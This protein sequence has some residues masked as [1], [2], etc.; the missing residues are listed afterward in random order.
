MNLS[1]RIKLLSRIGN[2]FSTICK[3]KD[4]SGFPGF[5]KIY[6]SNPW[7]TEEFVKF[8]LSEWSKLLCYENLNKW[9]NKY[10]ISD[11][12]DNKTMLGLILAG[13][14]PLVGFHDLICGF[15]TGINI[16]I[17]LSSKDNILMKWAI[18]NFYNECPDLKNH[19]IY[20]EEK[21][22]NNYNAI[23]ATGSNNT[24][25]YFEYYF[26]NHPNILRKNRSSVAILNGKESINELEALADDVF[27][28]FGLGCRNVSKIYL[29]Y[30][31]DFNNLGSAFQKYYQ[32]KNHNKYGNN[33]DYQYAMIGMNQIEH[34]NLG[35]LLLLER[36]E[37]YSPISIVNF[38][39]YSDL[40]D[41]KSNLNLNSEKIQCIV[42]SE[43]ITESTLNFG[44]TQKPQIFDYADNIDTIKFILNLQNDN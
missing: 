23:I 16:N 17:K 36:D 27:L 4:Y 19:I 38:E 8:S 15:V 34:V 1:Q 9:T 22:I 24:N 6:H 7:F 44:E 30:N 12:T 21:L 10:K 20:T 40:N 32:L 41:I 18:E 43:K 3:M 29:P 13:N 35:H 39:Y 5:E 26:S 31:Y 37:L 25:R 2:I 14:I 28:Y 11:N 42:S 33:F